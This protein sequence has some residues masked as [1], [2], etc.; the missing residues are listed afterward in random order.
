MTNEQSSEIFKEYIEGKKVIF[1][2]PARNLMNRNLGEWIDEFDVV[3]RTNGSKVLNQKLWKDYGKKTN[4]CYFNVQ[5]LREEHPFPILEMR[6]CGTKHIVFK[7]CSKE[8]RSFYEK[9]FNV[10]DVSKLIHVMHKQIDGLLM[11]PIIL[12]DLLQ[13]K[14]RE[15]FITGIDCYVT[16][17][18]V[19]I[20]GDYREYYPGYLGEKIETKANIANIGRVDPHLKKK[21]NTQYIKDLINSNKVKTHNFVL[22]SI[23]TALKR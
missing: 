9:H 23:E 7:S 3:V 20:P 5:H 10:R 18:P 4:I 17:P 13:F 16:K 2:G 12:T 14:P 11:G 22:K 19:F 15:L 8:I 1:V 21:D 6:S